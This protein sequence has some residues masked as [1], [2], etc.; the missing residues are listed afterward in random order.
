M[1]SH[2]KRTTAPE[3]TSEKLLL[4]RLHLGISQT[5]LLIR[6]GVQHAID[7][8]TISKY[9]LNKNEPPLQ[10]LLAYARLANVPV[11]YLID[12]QIDPDVVSKSLQDVT[13]VSETGYFAIGVLLR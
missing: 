9:E 13:P 2:G 3:V 10:I 4:I 5:Q 1:I 8:T 11:E 12:D 6:L 7:Y